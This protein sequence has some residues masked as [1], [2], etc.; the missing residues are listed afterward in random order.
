MGETVNMAMPEPICASPAAVL[1]PV[2]SNATLGTSMND[3]MNAVVA[4]IDPDH[5]NR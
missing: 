4:N 5:R 3:I 2:I 1:L